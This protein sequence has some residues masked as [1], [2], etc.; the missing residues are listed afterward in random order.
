MFVITNKV[1]FVGCDVHV[2]GLTSWK[3]NPTYGNQ[4]A[5]F[6]KL[7][8][9]WPAQPIIDCWYY[10]LKRANTSDTKY[11]AHLIK[12]MTPFRCSIWLILC[13]SNLSLPRMFESFNNSLLQTASNSSVGRI[14]FWGFILRLLASFYS[15][16]HDSYFEHLKF[17]DID[18]HVFTNGSKQI[19]EG[20]SPY[21]NEEFRYPPI[22]GLLFV[23]NI[24]LNQ[25][26]GKLFLISADILAGHL[27]YKLNIYQGVHRVN[28]KLFLIIWLFNPFTVVISSRGSFEPIITLLV[29]ASLYFLSSSNHLIAGLIYGLS[30]YTKMYPVIYC[31]LFYAYISERKPYM[32]NQSKVFYWFKT[33]APTRNHFKFYLSCGFSL[34]SLTY[35][36]YRSYGQDYLDSSLIYHLKRRDFQHNFS[37]YFYLFRLLPEFQDH[38]S[39]L[40]F[41]LQFLGVLATSVLYI[42]LDTNR[43][44][45]LR[46]LTFGLFSSTFLFV[47]LNKVCTSQY[48]NWYL[49]FLPLILD[50]LKL[51]PSQAY[52]IVASWAFSQLNWLFFAYL[53]EYRNFDVLEMVGHSSILFLMSNLWILVTLCHNFDASKWQTRKTD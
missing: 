43:R 40:A 41:I 30:I 2:F 5:N 11:W 22:V 46:K 17:T 36:S 34:L 53:Y 29:L 6:N 38:L 37:I 27:Q 3:N 16:F 50:S 47:S 18:Y 26:I 28:S 7:Q 9:R 35:A 14:L 15:I 24:L 44:T 12:I 4:L 13:D 25:N 1:N 21:S 42:C 32:I 33:F 49:I 10:P 45:K 23:P 20:K 31:L 48:F 8:R 39:K 51:T 19:V 52:C